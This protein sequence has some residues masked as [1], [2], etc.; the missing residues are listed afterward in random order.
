[1]CHVIQDRLGALEGV[2][3]VAAD[4]HT[5]EV[6]VRWDGGADGSERIAEVLASAGFRVERTEHVDGNKELAGLHEA[7]CEVGVR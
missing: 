4:P 1:M 2:R 3:E 6:R 5:R 7:R